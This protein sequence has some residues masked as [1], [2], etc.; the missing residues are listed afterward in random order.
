MTTPS[1]LETALQ[2]FFLRTTAPGNADAAFQSWKAN[3]LERTLHRTASPE[4][5][6]REAALAAATGNDQRRSPATA[7]AIERVQLDR[8]RA[9][10]L[11]R[12]S[13]FN[14]ATFVVVGNLDAERLKPL[15]ERYFGSLPSLEKPDTWHDRRLK[16]ATGKVEQQ[17]NAGRD[18][19]SRLF[20]EFSAPDHYSLELARDTN[21]LQLLLQARLDEV[22]RER[23]S[24]VY[25]VG[26]AAGVDREPTQRHY[27]RVWLTC[28]PE[29]L[30]KVRTAVFEQLASLASSGIDQQHL[31][32]LAKQLRFRAAEDLLSEK[33]WLNSLSQAYYYGDDPERAHDIE[34]IVAR[35]T[36]DTVRDTARRIFDPKSY[37]VVSQNPAPATGTP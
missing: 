28:A 17:L 3:A 26:V 7:E 20:I 2:L 37:V 14:G 4:L 18:E 15:A 13:N 31:A 8:V 16:Y 30:E 33:W 23:L 19:R 24:S 25:T 29:N 9:L 36:S 6:F 10:W 21:A 5:L 35:L 1:D 12:T 22:L 11:Q 32:T 34:A 27:L